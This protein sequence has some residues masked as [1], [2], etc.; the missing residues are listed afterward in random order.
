ME[1]I[2]AF[3]GIDCSECAVFIASKENSEEKK[4]EVAKEWSSADKPL[5]SEDIHCKGCFD[6]TDIFWYCSSCPVRA[7]GL[8]KGVKNCAYCEKYPCL[9]LHEIYQEFTNPVKAIGRLQEIY[10]S[11]SRR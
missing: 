7:C 9:K 10:H 3:C 11:I 4:Q 6:S 1:K 2:I 8:E 5:Q